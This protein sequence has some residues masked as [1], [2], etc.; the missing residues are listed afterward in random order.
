MNKKLAANSLLFI[1]FIRSMSKSCYFGLP[2]WYGTGELAS[3]NHFAGYIFLTYPAKWLYL[4]EF[5][6]E[7]K[8]RKHTLDLCLQGRD[9][10]TQF[11]NPIKTQWK[12]KFTANPFWYTKIVC[13]FSLFIFFPF[14]SL[15]FCFF[16]PH[17]TNIPHY[18]GSALLKKEPQLFN[19]N[20]PNS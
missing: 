6:S 15:F 12:N 11:G 7:N 9:L 8:V 18:P 2:F 19:Y 3:Y 1:F 20:T 17:H 4:G 10:A 16:P 13:V 5:I 14:S